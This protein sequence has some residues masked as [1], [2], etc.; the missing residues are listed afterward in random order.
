MTDEKKPPRQVATAPNAA[1]QPAPTW[2]PPER[3]V[4]ETAKG[5][6]R[7]RPVPGAGSSARLVLD[8]N[9]AGEVWMHATC[10]GGPDSSYGAMSDRRLLTSVLPVILAELREQLKLGRHLT[11]AESATIAAAVRQSSSGSTV[12]V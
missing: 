6:D 3:H 8:L 1:T 9:Q 4:D 5:V 7:S 11:V 10:F 12:T 2:P